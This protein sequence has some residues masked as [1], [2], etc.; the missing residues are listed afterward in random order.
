MDTLNFIDCKVGNTLEH[1][2]TEEFP[3][4]STNGSGSNIKN[5]EDLMKLQRFWKSKYTVHRTEWYPTD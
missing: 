5:G 1:T 3:E 4:Q 2:G